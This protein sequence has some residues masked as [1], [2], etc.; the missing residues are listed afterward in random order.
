MPPRCGCSSGTR[1][2]CAAGV[3]LG[4]RVKLYSR[5][6]NSAGE[7]V[8]IALNLKGIAYEY[9]PVAS[10]P[11]GQYRRINPQGLMP[12]LAIDGAVIAQSGAILEFL[13]ERFPE[14]PLLPADP[15]L[16]AQ[17]RAFGDHIMAEM[18]AITV[19]RVREYVEHDLALG[20]EGVVRWA[21]HWLSLGFAALEATLAA[22]P[23]D[24]P[25]CFGEAPGWADVHLVPQLANGRRLQCDLSPYARLLAVEARC[26]GLDA[27]IRARPDMQSD[28]PKAAGV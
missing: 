16:R 18:H 20:S 5:W 8:R 11:P 9:V 7:R 28:A 17:V 4:A 27:F 2:S 22:R 6:Q 19:N 13:E 1:A 23:V 3:R 24:W 14:P 15:I 10:L 26:I 21:N 25:F 12:A